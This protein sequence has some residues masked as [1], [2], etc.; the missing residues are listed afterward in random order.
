M[1]WRLTELPGSYVLQPFKQGCVHSSVHVASVLQMTHMILTHGGIRQSNAMNMLEVY[2]AYWSAITHDFEHGGVN[3]DFLVNALKLSIPQL[4]CIQYVLLQVAV[5]LIL[6]STTRFLCLTSYFSAVLML[7]LRCNDVPTQAS[8]LCEKR[9]IRLV[10]S[11]YVWVLCLLSSRI[12]AARKYSYTVCCF[13]C[14]CSCMFS[15]KF[16]AARYTA[17]HSLMSVWFMFRAQCGMRV[18]LLL[19]LLQ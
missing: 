12:L 11:V 9:K 15:A 17:P 10:S 4:V 14:L 16:F 6:H 3:N 7:H 2:C 8:V 18:N 1:E 13:V 5:D 19:D